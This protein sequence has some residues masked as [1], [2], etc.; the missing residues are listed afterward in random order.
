MRKNQSSLLLSLVAVLPLSLFGCSN[1]ILD[2]RNAQVVN[3]KIYASDANKPFTGTVTNFPD[4]EILQGQEG[5]SPFAK[6]VAVG[7][8]PDDGR[9]YDLAWR[10]LNA[11]GAFNARTSSYC[12]VSVVDGYLDGKTVCKAPRTN[13]VGTEMSFK[14]GSLNGDLKYYNFNFT[15]NLLAEGSFKDGLPVGTQTVYGTK[16]S[17]KTV[18]VNWSEGVLNGVEEIYNEANG[19]LTGQYRFKD[20]KL[21]GPARR[22]DENG[23]LSEDLTF[24][25][26][27]Q[28]QT[29]IDKFKQAL[30][31]PVAVPAVSETAPAAN[32][33]DC[34]SAWTTAYRKER[35]DDIVVNI[36]QLDEWKQWCQQGKQAPAN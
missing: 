31:E 22:W 14:G 3:G 35:G 7:A 2:Y 20:G 28:V 36:D 25:D 18:I 24:R 9:H 1:Q 32:L 11:S 33:D 15:T 29:D 16:T 27:V 34:V 26:G 17:T 5:F 6:I 4:N 8:F 13:T 12:D 19:K 23:T 30:S 10:L 21:E